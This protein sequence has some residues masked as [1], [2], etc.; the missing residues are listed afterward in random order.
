LVWID[1]YFYYTAPEDE[2]LA[3]LHPK[4]IP[5]VPLTI[6][7]QLAALISAC[8]LRTI[9]WRGVRYAIDG[10][11]SVRRLDYAPYT[12]SPARPEHAESIV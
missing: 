10:R 3:T 8:R 1:G 5:V 2:P 6:V 12:D 11:D 7:L 4:H 9:D